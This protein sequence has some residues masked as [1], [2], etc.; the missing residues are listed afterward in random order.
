VSVLIG[1]QK[2]VVMQITAGH[3]FLCKIVL[4]ENSLWLFVIFREKREEIYKNAQEMFN[5][6]STLEN[7]IM[8]ENKLNT[9]TKAVLL[10]VEVNTLL[11]MRCFILSSKT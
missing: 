7:T 11:K 3:F 6:P 9:Q 1:F 8:K 10:F 4:Y 5:S 2:L